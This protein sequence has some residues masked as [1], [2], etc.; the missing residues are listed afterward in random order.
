MRG[1][2][3]DGAAAASWVGATIPG[4]CQA[5]GACRLNA[6]HSAPGLP[7]PPEGLPRDALGL[8]APIIRGAPPTR[9]V[10]AN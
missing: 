10:T 6:G 1:I 2:G 4:R 8:V 7:R 9:S 5:A 3:D